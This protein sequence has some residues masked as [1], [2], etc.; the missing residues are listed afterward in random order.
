MNIERVQCSFSFLE[1]GFDYLIINYR[2]LKMEQ[3]PID[4]E[5]E[6]RT[7][8]QR[9]GRMLREASSRLR[10][11]DKLVALAVQRC[12]TA[13]EYASERL[14]DD[15]DIVRMA[16][17]NDIYALE[18]VSVRLRD[19]SDFMKV[20][21]QRNGDSMAFA[22]DR[23]R[24]DLEL[25]KIACRNS[26]HIL[27][28][29]SPRIFGDIGIIKELVQINGTIICMSGCYRDDYD[30]VKLAFK[31]PSGQ[32]PVLRYVSERLRN[33]EEIVKLGLQKSSHAMKYVSDR[34][35]DNEEIAKGMIMSPYIKSPG[36]KF[37]SERLRDQEE[38]VL[39]AVQR[40][41]LWLE[42]VS[43][44]LRDNDTVVKVAVQQNGDALEFA[45]ERLQNVDEI[46]FSACR[47]NEVEENKMYDDLD[48]IK[49]HRMFEDE[50]IMMMMHEHMYNRS[51]C[52]PNKSQ[53]PLM[54]A[55]ERFRDHEALVRHVVK[56][57]PQVI[58]IASDRVQKLI[59]ETGPSGSSPSAQKEETTKKV[60]TAPVATK[61]IFKESLIKLTSMIGLTKVKTSIYEQLAYAITMAD[62]VKHSPPMLHTIITGPPGC[63]KSNLATI[64][65]NLLA[66]ISSL[67]KQ[68]DKLKIQA[69]SL[70]DYIEKLIA[71]D[72]V[73]APSEPVKFV[74]ASRDDLIG[75]YQGHTA[76]KTRNIIKSALG[77][78][79]YID[80]AYQLLNNEEGKDSFGRECLTTLNEAM[81]EHP[82]DLIVIFSGYSD[83]MEALFKVQPGLKRRFM[84]QFFVDPYSPDEI[85]QIFMK[86]MTDDDWKV[87]FSVDYLVKLITDNLKYFNYYGGSTLQLKYFSILSYC[88]DKLIKSDVPEYTITEAMI[89]N[90]LSRLKDNNQVQGAD[91]SIYQHMYG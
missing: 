76:V 58:H 7:L 2:S 47:L 26:R 61:N 68:P 63:G 45:S 51:N 46:V 17:Q 72:I 31:T 42:Y 64:I 10:D 38:L 4:N 18:F 89:E 91:L 66:S 33:H 25:V 20:F 44:R 50:H 36:F 6:L 69:E 55:N 70:E 52:G 11:D 53:S 74:K 81:S 37:L 13:L 82:D 71:S 3:H 32:I 28:F 30:I 22:S 60:V 12:G 24:D 40:N 88:R 14:R 39:Q 21:L 86:Q 77:G 83:C 19:D 9:D 5:T 90:G 73:L 85:A 48:L 35:R 8:L 80:E 29:V 27:K 1:K 78:V 62:K 23:I 43:D 75:K 87:T 41:G 56:R 15:D 65:A 16:C 54:W 59:R 34:L 84:W 57:Y 67:R 49:H 79:L